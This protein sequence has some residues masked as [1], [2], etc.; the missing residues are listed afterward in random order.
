MKYQMELT[1][2]RQKAEECES[3]Y[4]KVVPTLSS[5]QA[6]E[7]MIRHGDSMPLSVQQ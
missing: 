7:S 1:Q 3:N 4:W 2:V 6:K 5:R